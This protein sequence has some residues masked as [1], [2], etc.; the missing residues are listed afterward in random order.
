MK[1]CIIIAV[2]RP[3]QTIGE[4]GSLAIAGVSKIRDFSLRS[5]FCEMSCL[6]PAY[7]VTRWTGGSTWAGSKGDGDTS[8]L[9]VHGSSRDSPGYRCTIVDRAQEERISSHKRSA[10]CCFSP[11][12]SKGSKTR[13]A[14]RLSPTQTP[15][16][17]RIKLRCHP[18][19][20]S[21]RPTPECD[22]APVSR[23]NGRRSY[24]EKPSHAA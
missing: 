22:M 1:R 5:A 17:F 12:L 23:N 19:H 10:G 7:M 11:K 15:E 20:H 14:H 24:T 16:G 21:A 4:R 13:C 3:H 8:V 2:R 9:T 6:P 18:N